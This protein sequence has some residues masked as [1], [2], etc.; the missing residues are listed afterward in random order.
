MNKTKQ[1]IIIML[2]RVADAVLNT[3]MRPKLCDDIT[4]VNYF[5]PNSNTFVSCL[6]T[7]LPLKRGDTF[8]VVC[9]SDTHDTHRHLA[10]PQADIL[11]HAG[12]IQ[13]TSRRFSSKECEARCADF[14]AWLGSLPVRTKIVVGGNHDAYLESLGAVKAK[15]V[16]SNA[17]YLVFEDTCVTL[18]DN[19]PE[20]PRL[21]VYGA[22]FSNGS[23]SNAAYQLRSDSSSDPLPGHTRRRIPP[24]RIPAVVQAVQ[25]EHSAALDAALDTLPLYDI[26]VTHDPHGLR[27]HHEGR[28]FRPSHL[29]VGGHLHK[30]Y[31]AAT[32]KDV[33]TVVACNVG[34]SYKPVNPAIVVDI[35]PRDTIAKMLFSLEGK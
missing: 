17:R 23:S 19:D 11:I 14:N 8:R 21:F 27:I 12:D 29:H 3:V 28:T 24:T 6:P 30:H 4:T 13:L 20:A 10:I 9:I 26:F 5:D 31:G 32:H 16:L 1:Q 25:P 15:E 18:D 2:H 35:T 7:N 33:T 22:P 34:Q